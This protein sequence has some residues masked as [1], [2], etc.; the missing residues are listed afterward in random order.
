MRK[1]L[2]LSVLALGLCSCN[3]RSDNEP[4][5]AGPKILEDLPGNYTFKSTS[6]ESVRYSTA[7]ISLVA[8]GEYQI[9]RITV[10]GPVLYS[11]SLGEHAVVESA[12]LG[13]GAV[14]YQPG[15]RKTTIRFE[16]GGYLCELSK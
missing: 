9:S 3:G 6:Q 12:E 4:V 5:E 13:Q 14:T 8:P 2:F 1:I 16:K 7:V 10:Y 15:I 11:F